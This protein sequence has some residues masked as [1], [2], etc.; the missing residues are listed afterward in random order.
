MEESPLQA[1]YTNKIFLRIYCIMIFFFTLLACAP[2]NKAQIDSFEYVW[3]RVDQTFPYPERLETWEEI[4]AQ[5]K[6]KAY[7]AKSAQELHLARLIR[8]LIWGGLNQF[9]VDGRLVS[10][11]SGTCCGLVR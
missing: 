5:T 8:N 4:Y 3:K 1:Q 7:K 11:A 6:P 2:K 9:C 10:V